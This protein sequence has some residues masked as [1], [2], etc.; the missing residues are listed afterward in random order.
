MSFKFSRG[1]TPSKAASS[2]GGSWRDLVY[3]FPNGKV[4][5]GADLNP[6]AVPIGTV[7]YTKDEYGGGGGGSGGGSTRPTRPKPEGASGPYG[8][9]TE[10]QVSS[11]FAAAGV[12]PAIEGSDGEVIETA[13]QRLARLAFQLNSGQRTEDDVLNEIYGGPGADV[14]SGAM[15][16]GLLSEVY[17]GS[18]EIWENTETG[19]WFLSYGVPGTDVPLLYSITSSQLKAIFADAA[20]R[21]DRRVRNSTLH[22]LGAIFAGTA[23][24]PFGNPYIDFI[25]QLEKEAQF[26]PWLRDEDMLA[27]M[28]EAALEGREP[29]DAELA[30]TNWWQ[31]HSAA[32]REWLTNYLRDPAS[33]DAMIQSAQVSTKQQLESLGISNAPS[34]LV[35][36]LANKLVTGDWTQAYWSEQVRGLSDPYAKVAMDAELKSEV[37]GLSAPLDTTAEYEE[38]VRAEVLNWLGP[39]YGKWN[40]S[41]IAQWAGRL[42][43]DP[44]A[45]DALTEVLRNQRMSLFPEYTNTQLTYEDIAEPWRRVWENTWRQP[46]DETDPLFLEIIRANDYQ[47]AGQ[48]LRAEGLSR[49]VKGVGDELQAA[50]TRQGQQIRSF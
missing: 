24:D 2:L 35:N 9:Y 11:W 34:S 44:D 49:G 36:F 17:G 1:D 47:L 13:D 10:A 15:G 45:S 6:R 46:V 27:V 40:D 48:R 12:D 18:P 28:F 41:K 38:R 3:V 8:V 25:E 14:Q 43:N 29:T 20:P 22:E 31:T 26:Q 7:A 37:T 19:E 32:Q 5:Q 4:V 21:A 42:R 33:A 39:V 50:A 30:T 16:A 23:E